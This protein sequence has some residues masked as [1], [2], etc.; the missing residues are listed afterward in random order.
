MSANAMTRRG[1]SSGLAVLAVA[2]LSLA[3]CATLPSLQGRVETTAIADYSG[4]P[5][6]D[7]LQAPLA[8]HPGLSGIYALRDG[9]DAF[10][11][12]MTMIDAAARSLDVQYYI[13]DADVTGRLA[14][15]G[16]RRAAERGVRVRLLLDDNNTPGLDPTLAALDAHPNIEVRLFNPF[17]QRGLRLMGFATDFARLNRR[18]HNKSLTAD[19]AATIVGGRNIG[20]E[21]FAAGGDI[22]FL[23]LDVVG[24]GPVVRDVARSFDAYWRSQS[25]Y[26]LDRL[27]PAATP[28]DLD[29]LARLGDEARAEQGAARYLAS[30][31]RTRV[32]RD[33][34]AQ[35]LPFIWANTRVVVDD[36][37]KGLGKAPRDNLL[38][39]DL[40]GAFGQPAAREL[41]IVSPYFV[42][43][44]SGTRSLVR[45]AA[46]GVKVKVLTN[47]LESTDVAA[48]HSG[49]ARRRRTLLKAGIE[50]YELRRAA[51]AE[52]PGGAPLRIVPGAPARKSERGG[53]S[54]R[55]NAVQP[56][57]T[58]V[59]SSGGGGSLGSSEASLHAKTFAVDRERIFIGSLNFDPRS[60]LHNTELGFVI[61]SPSMAA[62][63]SDLFLKGIPE[64]S[65]QVQLG[66]QGRLQWIERRPGAAPVYHSNEPGVSVGRRVA[67]TVLGLLPI[68]GLL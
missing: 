23:D 2:L 19:G 13:W 58:I 9:E 40:R 36:P 62:T 29:A 27:I 59:G 1:K 17:M 57:A 5:I 43:G 54:R 50:L 34:V 41:V 12:R 21:Y 56:G 33:I 63:L 22:G 67:V 35:E 8:T 11:A 51:A 6:H 24:V 28:E 30:V 60:A 14:F 25:S 18:M 38:M 39:F 64:A 20:D 46:S 55:R 26:P 68:E 37:A 52:T 44:R 4:T 31:A 47:A 3:G 65:Y 15:D 7:A 42:P 49:Y 10:A 53:R 61:D 45:L 48:V 16:L 66:P 32:M